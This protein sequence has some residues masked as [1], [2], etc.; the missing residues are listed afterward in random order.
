MHL[1]TTGLYRELEQREK[2]TV[3]KAGMVKAGTVGDPPK[4]VDLWL[5]VQE[6]GD[7]MA[8]IKRFRHGWCVITSDGWDIEFWKCSQLTPVYRKETKS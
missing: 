8:K 1:C 4:G 3:A 6:G 2:S 5:Y 7:R